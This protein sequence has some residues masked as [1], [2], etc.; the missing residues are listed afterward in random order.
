MLVDCQYRNSISSNP[1]EGAEDENG[2]D[3]QHNVCAKDDEIKV[4]P[5]K[6]KA[7]SLGLAEAIRKR[8]PRKLAETRWE[9]VRNLMSRENIKEGIKFNNDLNTISNVPDVSKLVDCLWKTEDSLSR[10]PETRWECHVKTRF[11]G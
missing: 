9:Q 6:G 2:Q 4:P 3:D 1:C 8:K 7:Q 10:H 11:F 5:Y